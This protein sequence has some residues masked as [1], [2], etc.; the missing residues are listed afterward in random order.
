[1]SSVLP[2]ASET[3]TDRY[4]PSPLSNTQ[5][6]T[7]NASSASPNRVSG[8]M[9]RMGNWISKKVGKGNSSSSEAPHV[10]PSLA[11]QWA[12]MEDEQTERLAAERGGYEYRR[13]EPEDEFVLVDV[14]AKP[15]DHARH[16]ETLRRRAAEAKGEPLSSPLIGVGA[17]PSLTSSIRIVSTQEHVVLPPQ[18]TNV[19]AMPP[20]V[21]PVS[22][23]SSAA[24]TNV[25]AA[26]SSSSSSGHD[27]EHKG[28]PLPLDASSSTATSGS[29]QIATNVSPAAISQ[30]ALVNSILSTYNDPS[31]LR[32]LLQTSTPPPV[33]PKALFLNCSHAQ[34]LVRFSLFRRRHHCRL[35]SLIFCDNCL[36]YR[37]FLP[38]PGMNKEAQPLCFRCT[39][40]ILQPWR[41]HIRAEEEKR[42]A[43][44]ILAAQAASAQAQH[45]AIAA[46]AMISSMPPA[47]PSSALPP[48]S[49]ESLG[50]TVTPTSGVVVS[51]HDA[52]EAELD[53]REQTARDERR[54]LER[55]RAAQIAAMDEQV[56]QEQMDWLRRE[57]E[58]R[59]MVQHIM[60]GHVHDQSLIP[61]PLLALNSSSPSRPPTVSS[62]SSPAGAVTPSEPSSA[63]PPRP[64][65]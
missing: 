53:R 29:D 50:A 1:M 51:D 39:T 49:Y 38:F 54:Q 31:L 24:T 16:E 6:I 56:R 37:R 18:D 4:Q 20:L 23:P 35:C 41:Q 52:H 19:A 42:K 30:A 15:E 33:Q 7:N 46:A 55:A 5:S 59:A 47:R 28:E 63:S 40:T 65:L 64:L 32:S 14:A 12:E 21:V 62:S 9:G 58:A 57:E 45:A 17:A 60:L 61:S 8:L 48:P 22:L 27:G 26:T 2:R 13:A 25:A 43:Q 3:G 11:A 34:C 10:P 44:T 36:P